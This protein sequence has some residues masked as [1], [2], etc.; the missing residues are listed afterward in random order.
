[1]ISRMVPKGPQDGLPESRLEHH[2]F[3][4]T[5]FERRRTLVKVS[6]LDAFS[7]TAGTKRGK[8]GHVAN[9]TIGR[10]LETLAFAYDV[11]F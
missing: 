5:S 6:F 3:W 11:D 2:R 4:G 7:A 8:F 10:L 1:M 9:L